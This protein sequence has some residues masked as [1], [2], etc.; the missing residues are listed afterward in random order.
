[1]LELNSTLTLT[2]LLA[3]YG[4]LLITVFYVQGADCWMFMEQDLTVM[5]PS[6]PCSQVFP[7]LDTA[8]DSTVQLVDEPQYIYTFKAKK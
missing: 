6:R 5:P 8:I 4:T 1:M 7:S 2:L 3:L